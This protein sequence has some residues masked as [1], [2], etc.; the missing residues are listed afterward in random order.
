MVIFI[1][2]VSKLSYGGK[3]YNTVLIGNQCWLK[4]NLDIGT[5]ING[6][7]NSANNTTIEKY[8]YSNDP[9]NCNTY[10]GLYQWEEAMK[11]VTTEG[12][13]GICPTGWHIPT[14]A[15]FQTLDTAVTHDGNSLKAVGQGSGGGA[16]T[17]T[18]GFSALLAG[19]KQTNSSFVDLGLRGHFWSSTFLNPNVPHYYL[20]NDRSDFTRHD[21]DYS[22]YG[23][24]VRCIKD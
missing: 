8:C 12:N 6:S 21:G 10:G 24:S 1:C 19:N 14:L 16:G 3:D 17:N 9:N 7:T 4:E 18:T 13:Q 20:W 2:G 5:M 15:E 11:Y 22:T 23:F